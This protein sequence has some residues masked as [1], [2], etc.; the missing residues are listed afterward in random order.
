MTL[1]GC[2]LVPSDDTV[3]SLFGAASSA[4]VAAV[5]ERIAAPYDRI[6]EGVPV[7]SLRVRNTTFS[8]RSAVI[9]TR[10]RHSMGTDQVIGQRIRRASMLALVLAVGAVGM[11]SAQDASPTANASPALVMASAIPGA[12]GGAPREVVRTETG[13]IDACALLTSAQIEAVIGSPV[14]ETT[15][16]RRPRVSL[17]RWSACGLPGSRRAVDRRIVL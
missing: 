2:L 5:G 15:P 14:V 10:R 7:T 11:A 9:P 13:A 6:S 12:S 1:L 16:I 17:D 4:D 3:F 8:G